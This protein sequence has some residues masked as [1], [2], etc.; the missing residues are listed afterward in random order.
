[1]FAPSPELKA[2]PLVA[3]VKCLDVSL[4]SADP[5]YILWG[6]VQAVQ[7]VQGQRLRLQEQ[8]ALR[9]RVRQKD[10]CG[11]V[12]GKGASRQVQAHPT[13]AWLRVAE[14][15]WYCNL[16]HCTALPCT[17]HPH[18][19]VVLFEHAQPVADTQPDQVH[20][21]LLKLNHQLLQLCMGTGTGRKV[22]QVM[23]QPQA[24]KHWVMQAWGVGGVLQ[25]YLAM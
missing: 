17:A 10:L 12:M 21:V 13:V 16:L 14:L 15:A 22:G 23:S 9:V 24:D 4:G 7:A 2:R 1:M 25:G 3:S 19:P 18:G 8:T 6:A 20:V 11:L 5:P